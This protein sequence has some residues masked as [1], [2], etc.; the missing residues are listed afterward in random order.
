LV[1]FIN[2]F[3][4]IGGGEKIGVFFMKQNSELNNVMETA[5]IKKNEVMK[6]E[7]KYLF[8]VFLIFVSQ[9]CQG[10][11]QGKPKPIQHNSGVIMFGIS[12]SGG[13]D[14]FMETCQINLF[15]IN[16][17]GNI[18]VIYTAETGVTYEKK[19]TYKGLVDNWAYYYD[20]DGYEYAFFNGEFVVLTCLNYPGISGKMLIVMNFNYKKEGSKK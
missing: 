2:A 19:F 14:K 7:K 4:G 12:Y 15:T 10:Q 5:T 8:L 9:F 3:G 20:S 18:E 16:Q 11:G 1:K 13:E 17:E 6:L